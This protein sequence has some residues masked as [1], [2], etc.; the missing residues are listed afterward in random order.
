MDKR[1]VAEHAKVCPDDALYFRLKALVHRYKHRAERKNLSKFFCQIPSTLEGSQGSE[2]AHSTSTAK[3]QPLG[4]W[5]EMT[6]CCPR[7]VQF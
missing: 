4:R 2:L 5:R 6:A 7:C 1:D 3:G